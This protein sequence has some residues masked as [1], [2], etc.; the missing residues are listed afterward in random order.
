LLIGLQWVVAWLAVRVAAWRRLIK[1]EPRLLAWRG[2]LNE[3]ALREE[4]MSPEEVYT[5]VRASG[6]AS[7]LEAEAA[8]LE[9]DGSVSV[10]KSDA[11]E[12]NTSALRGVH[13][14]PPDGKLPTP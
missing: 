7:L 9:T 11:K 8:V 4:R 10:I 2:E 12:R 3:A 14:F 1:S 6:S 5:A 13:G